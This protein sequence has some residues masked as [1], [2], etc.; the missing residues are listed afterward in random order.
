MYIVFLM[1]SN[2]CLCY[3]LIDFEREII[4]VFYIYRIS[5]DY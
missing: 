5:M 1:M 4:M 2:F 3:L